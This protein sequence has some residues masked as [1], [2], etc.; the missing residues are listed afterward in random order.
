MAPIFTLLAGLLPDVI[1][2]VLPAEKMSEAEAAKLQAD[3]TLELL[4]QDWSKVEA[5]YE[6]RASARQLAAAD[7]AKGNALTGVLA[8]CVR[9]A[10]GFGA[11]AMVAWSVLAGHEINAPLQDII[12][13]VLFFYFGGR[14]L[15]RRWN[16][17]RRRK[18]IKL[19]KK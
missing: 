5:E 19:R 9:P 17:C 18:G 7:I 15:G 13:T 2:R 11:L 6:D 8:A 16:D 12:Q 1:K 3:M 10:W 14:H 4:K